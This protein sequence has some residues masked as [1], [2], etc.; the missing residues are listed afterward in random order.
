[1][2][3]AVMMILRLIILLLLLPLFPTPAI[4]WRD[5]GMLL[6]LTMLC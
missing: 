1:M 5:G 3:M 6:L 2:M 4:V